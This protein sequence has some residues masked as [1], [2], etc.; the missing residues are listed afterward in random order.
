[1]FNLTS[2]FFTRTAYGTDSPK[3]DQF[4]FRGVL[5]G[6]GG[7]CAGQAAWPNRAKRRDRQ[8]PIAD[9]KRTYGQEVDGRAADRQLQRADRQARKQA[10]IQRL[11]SHSVGMIS[12]DGATAPPRKADRRS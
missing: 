11:L 10:A 9:W 8:R 5:G 12:D 6:I 3:V 7:I 4:C 2:G 1:M